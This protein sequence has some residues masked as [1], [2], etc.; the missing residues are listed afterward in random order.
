MPFISVRGIFVSITSWFARFDRF[1]SVHAVRSQDTITDSTGADSSNSCGIASILMIN[2][3][4][5]KH[6]M[7]AGMSAGA[8]IASSGVPLG[9]YIGSSLARGAFNQ[10]VKEEPAIY[11]IYSDVTGSVYDGSTYSNAS[12]YPEVLRQIGLSGWECVV[13]S[14]S[15]VFDAV[16]TATDAGNPVI[17]RVGWNNNGGGHFTVIDQVHPSGH[18]CVC[19]PWDAELRLIKGSSGNVIN[20]D[21]TSSVWS[22]SLGGNR[23]TGGN[24]GSF[25]GCIVRKKS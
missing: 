19:D 16:K 14:P 2:F 4:M 15:Q 17:A 22:F 5:K 9:G 12:F 23:H 21:S 24:T 6:L 1:G 25:S 11:K 7:L 10:A 13:L 20:Y 3:K 18:V 8:A